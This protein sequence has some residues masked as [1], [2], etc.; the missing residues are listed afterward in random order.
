[1]RQNWPFF[2]AG[3]AGQ[4]GMPRLSVK[5]SLFRAGCVT[6]RFWSVMYLS[7]LPPQI[8]HFLAGAKNSYFLGFLR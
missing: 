2:A 1:M 5:N 4:F 8:A 7:T 6:V 3:K